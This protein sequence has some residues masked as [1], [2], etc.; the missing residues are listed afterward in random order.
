[1]KTKRMMISVVS[2]AALFLALAGVVY[3]VGNIDATN[4]WTWGGN[5]GWLNFNP[6]HGGVTV[7]DDH[8]EGYAWAENIGWVRLGTYTGGGAHTYANDA[9]DTYGVN[10]DGAGNLSGYAWGTNVGWINFNPTHER[11]TVDPD[12]GEFD[13]YAWAENVG[14]IHFRNSGTNAYS[15]IA[16]WRDSSGD[17]FL[18]LIFKDTTP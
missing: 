17:I 2:I 1:M 16:D 6:T 15:V 12:T 13:G 8:L 14:W 5:I 3:A 9:A 18:P 10:N 7:Y 4:K 11:V